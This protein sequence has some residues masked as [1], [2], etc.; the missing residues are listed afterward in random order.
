MLLC[1]VLVIHRQGSFW[2]H[3]DANQS[4]CD[5][6][7]HQK[8]TFTFLC[9]VTLT[10]DLLTWNVPNL[11]SQQLWKSHNEILISKYINSKYTRTHATE[12]YTI[13]AVLVQ[14]WCCTTLTWQNTN[15]HSRK[16]PY[17]ESCGKYCISISAMNSLLTDCSSCEHNRH[18]RLISLWLS[19]VVTAQQ[20][21]PA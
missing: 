5:K 11:W 12:D 10:F 13:T 20:L 4:T 14:C 1:C 6:Y 16:R 9:P 17:C 15:V 7:E 3:F 18:T 19:A 21:T 2:F 8:M